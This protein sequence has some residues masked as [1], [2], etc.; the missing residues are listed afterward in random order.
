MLI[1]G[2]YLPRS[3]LKDANV[4]D[5]K[6]V[7]VCPAV[8]DKKAATS[9]TDGW[10]GRAS[11]LGD[12][13]LIAYTGYWINGDAQAPSAGGDHAVGGRYQNFPSTLIDSRPGGSMV[14]PK[15]MTLFRST[16][17]VIVADGWS[18][19]AFSSIARITGARHGRW[20]TNKS[21]SSGTTNML[22]LDGHAEPASR[23]DLPQNVNELAGT[24][25]Q[26]RDTRYV[27]NIKQKS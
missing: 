22:F 14:A 9:D 15:K 1:I 12:P 27:F 5:G 6:S 8:R 18:W 26:M 3:A 25:A 23:N 16:E 21:I 4:L 10:E 11:Q 20:Q 19:D 2:K 7:L 13:T 24:R 17:T